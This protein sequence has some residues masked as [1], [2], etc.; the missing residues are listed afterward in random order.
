MVLEILNFVAMVSLI[1]MVVAI[2]LYYLTGFMRC[3]GDEYR[4]WRHYKYWLDR[5]YRLID[6]GSRLMDVEHVVKKII[7][8]V[9][10]ND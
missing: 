7:E 9:E 5:D 6:L 3:V 1:F 2:G 4:S 8:K 10:I